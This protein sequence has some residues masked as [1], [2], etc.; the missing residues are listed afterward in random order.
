MVQTTTYG[1]NNNMNNMN[2]MNNI[3]ITMLTMSGTWY[4]MLARYGGG[5]GIQRTPARRQ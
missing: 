3:N 2:N 4:W 1:S 5:I